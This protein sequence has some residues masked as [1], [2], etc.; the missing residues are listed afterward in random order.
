[1]PR[2]KKTQEDYERSEMPPAS[3]V[4]VSSQMQVRIPVELY[5]RYGF[6]REAWCVPTEHGVEFRPVH[7]AAQ[8]STNIL[9]ELVAQGLTGEELVKTFKSRVQ[10]EVGEKPLAPVVRDEGADG[11][12]GDPG[13]AGE[14]AGDDT[15]V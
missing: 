6:T 2:K 12:K 5:Q 3:R 8:E 1:M 4:R 11:T 14:S 13:R 7:G 15:P 9:Q 10:M